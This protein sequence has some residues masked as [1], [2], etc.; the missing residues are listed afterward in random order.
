MI[1]AYLRSSSTESA[2]LFIVGIVVGSAIMSVMLAG[3]HFAFFDFL[4]VTYTNNQVS[5]EI[6]SG[7]VSQ[8]EADEMMTHSL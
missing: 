5:L 1:I 8:E 4:P 6:D 7:C 2:Q 3:I